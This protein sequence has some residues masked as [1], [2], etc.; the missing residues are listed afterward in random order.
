MDEYSGFACGCGAKAQ[1]RMAAL[2]RWIAKCVYEGKPPKPENYVTSLLYELA[3]PYS[4]WVKEVPLDP[5]G[6]GAIVTEAI[7][8]DSLE[9]KEGL[10]C[11]VQFDRFEDG[12]ALTLRALY[13][14]YGK[15][16]KYL[17]DVEDDEEDEGAG[18][19]V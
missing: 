5:G 13:K 15:G 17:E 16:R 10:H 19:A 2:H 4:A 18:E 1:H 11:F 7:D 9:P 14:K 12:L 6:W 3:A 8:S